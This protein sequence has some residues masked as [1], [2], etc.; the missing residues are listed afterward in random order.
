M[1]QHRLFLRNTLSLV[2]GLCL[3]IGAFNLIVDPYGIYNLVKIEGFNNVKPPWDHQE[4]MVKTLQLRKLRPKGIIIGSSRTNYGLDPEY[5]ATNFDSTP[6]YNLSLSFISTA[7]IYNILKYANSLNDLNIVIIGLDFFSFNIFHP[8]T[9]S[10]D[11]LDLASITKFGDTK[12]SSFVKEFQNTLFSSTATEKSFKAIAYKGKQTR[13]PYGQK[14]FI[15]E[16]S[17]RELSNM[18]FP[19]YYEHIWFPDKNRMFCL[20][21]ENKEGK[22]F[23]QLEKIINF[24]IRNNIEL[25]LFINPVHAD[26]LE[27]LRFMDLWPLYEN[28]KRDLVDLIAA[29]NNKKLKETPISLWDF[30][31]YNS[32]TTEKIPISTDLGTTMKG[33]IDLAHYKKSVGDLIL[34]KLLTHPNSQKITNT[35]FGHLINPGNIKKYLNNINGNQVQYQNENREYLEGMRVLWREL[36]DIQKSYPCTY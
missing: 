30:G 28:W 18:A 24:S 35:D 16:R 3:I 22:K 2:L 4:R 11:F 36:K 27:M 29:I 12:I 1:K 5:V 34:D 32:I 10:N 25:K 23:E 17:P 26:L 19:R 6:V 7:E 8:D 33:Y 31:D 14:L 15:D 20:Y 13:S 21:N 9:I